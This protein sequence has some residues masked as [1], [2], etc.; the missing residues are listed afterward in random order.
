MSITQQTQ[1][2]VPSGAVMSSGPQVTVLSGAP[3]NAPISGVPVTVSIQDSVGS[4]SLT[5]TLTVNTNASGVANF[6]NITITGDAGQY[7]LRFTVGGASDNFLISNQFTVNQ[8]YF[9][10]EHASSFGLCVDETL[11]TITIRDAAGDPVEDY[12]GTVTLSNSGLHGS[13]TV[14]TGQ[15]SVSNPSAGVAQY[16]FADADDGVVVLA[17]STNTA[18]TITFDANDA[19]N[20][21]ATRDY[22]LSMEIGA[23]SVTITHNGTGGSCSVNGI[24][25]GVIDSAGNPAIGYIG[26]VTISSDPSTGNW[27]NPLGGQGTLTNGG[28]NDGEA[29]YEF[30]VDDNAEV[31]LGYQ[32]ST[33][34]TYSFDATT[35][36]SLSVSQNSGDL[37]L[38]AS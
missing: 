22:A 16:T 13:Y 35:S 19:V 24:T 30:H 2:V 26:I 8:D 34:G 6:N 14:E 10:I 15:N 21:I 12:T 25:L 27:T 7:S 31:V 3:G 17:Y 4:P 32:N 1:A 33:G 18:G 37:E 5:G 9:T 29:S 23:C 11:I 28:G 36:D 38:S 20:E